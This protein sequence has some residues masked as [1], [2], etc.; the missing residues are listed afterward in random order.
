MLRFPVFSI[1]APDRKNH[2]RDQRNSYGYGAAGPIAE[3][4]SSAGFG[5]RRWGRLMGAGDWGSGAAFFSTPRNLW[6]AEGGSWACATPARLLFQS[7]NTNQSAATSSRD[8]LNLAPE[9]EHADRPSAF[10]F[11]CFDGEAS[12]GARGIIFARDAVRPQGDSTPPP[13]TARRM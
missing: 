9:S 8:C 2:R 13:V 3:V 10:I 1:P 5:K 4:P 7:G 11:F 6:G 12:K